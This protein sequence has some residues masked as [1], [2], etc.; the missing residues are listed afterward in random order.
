M[1]KL[2]PAH[3]VKSKNPRLGLCYE[4]SG[5]YVSRHQDCVLVHGTIQGCG[6]PPNPH[7]WAILPDGDVHDPVADLTLSAEAH[8]RIFSAVEQVRYTYLEVA[9]HGLR[10]GHWGPWH[11]DEREEKTA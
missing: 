11:D 10:T 1:K 9:T 3:K 6:Y 4:L 8:A 5:L 2:L 7:A